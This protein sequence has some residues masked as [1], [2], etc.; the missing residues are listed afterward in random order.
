M[1]HEQTGG[2]VSR[3][4]SDARFL[5]DDRGRASRMIYEYDPWNYP[6]AS[7]CIASRVHIP[8]I[9]ALATHT[10][11]GN[12]DG[13]ARYLFCERASIRL[14]DCQAKD[15]W[16]SR[17]KKHPSLDPLRLQKTIW[18]LRLV[19]E[20]RDGLAK[21]RETRDYKTAK[22]VEACFEAAPQ[23][24]RTLPKLG[25]TLSFTCCF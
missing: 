7:S 24:R 5:T 25:K 6:P 22:F 21:R 2:A 8:R 12:W 20:A 18:Q 1:S 13:V 14:R 17:K 11:E 3:L 9:R 10:Y 19:W 4:R 23:V 16:S 15:A